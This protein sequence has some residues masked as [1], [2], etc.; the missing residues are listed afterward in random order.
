MD[1][2][3]PGQENERPPASLQAQH[4][5]YRELAEAMPQ[6]VWTAHPDGALDYV[7]QQV[8]D[9]CHATSEDLIG[10]GWLSIVHPDDVAPSVAR[11]TRSIQT[12]ALYEVEFRLHRAHDQT[13][14]WHLGRAVPLRDAA[15]RI[16]KWLG[17]NTDIHDRKQVEAELGVAKAAADAANQAKS[18][19]L[20][21]MSHELRTPLNAIIGYSEMVMEEAQDENLDRIVEDARKI[22]SAGRHLLELI[23]AVLDL[24]KIEAG[25]MDLHV[26]PFSVRKLIG[27]IK[28]VIEPLVEQNHN[29]LRVSIEDQVVSKFADRMYADE[30]K[31]RQ[32]LL[33]LLGNACKFTT[34]GEI[35]LEVCMLDKDQISFAVCDTGIG[36]KQDQVGKLFEPF[37]QANQSTSRRFGGTGLGLAI[38]RRFARMMGGDITVRTAEGMG[39]TFTVSLPMTV[40]DPEWAPPAAG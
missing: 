17:T 10:A 31:V 26:E 11:W 4:L 27:E 1:R 6:Q 7:N 30:T 14:R 20:A 33:N 23:S 22:R 3:N 40:T 29:S 18:V 5:S 38:S 16:V 8:T 12:G 13:Y 28:S 25:K 36:M 35:T 2:R 24:S 32:I 19:F 34:R 9:Y 21:N 39:S 15:G 37:I